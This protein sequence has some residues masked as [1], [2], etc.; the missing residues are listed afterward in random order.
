MSFLVGGL[1]LRLSVA[2]LYCNGVLSPRPV[3]HGPR[4]ASQLSGTYLPDDFSSDAWRGPCLTGRGDNGRMS[5]DYSKS[6]RVRSTRI[7]ALRA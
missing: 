5:I 7:Y 3:R 4:Q 6:R 2:F 1:F